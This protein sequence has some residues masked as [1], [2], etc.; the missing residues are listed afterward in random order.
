MQDPEKKVVHAHKLALSG[1]F[2]VVSL[3]AC[4]RPQAGDVALETVTMSRPESDCGDNGRLDATLVGAIATQVQW[5]QEDFRCESMQRPDADGVRL[6][7]SGDVDGERLAI[8]ISAAGLKSGQT[9]VE[10][11]SNVTVTVEGSGRF[12]STPDLDSC[13]TEIDYQKR[14]EEDG[15]QFGIAGALFCI[16]PLGELNGDASVTISELSFASTINWS[17][18]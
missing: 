10:L 4:D 12:F 16:A 13:W 8:I 11:P 3:A 15:N 18:M 7:F 17:E 14:L 6:R 2:F 9:E 5:S 1:L